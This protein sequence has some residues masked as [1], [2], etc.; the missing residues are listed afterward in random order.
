M[1]ALID[2]METS[3]KQD[4][5]SDGAESE[6]MGSLEMLS[7][8]WRRDNV[9]PSLTSDFQTAATHL[10]E[11]EALGFCADRFWP[12]DED[13]EAITGEVIDHYFGR[14]SGWATRMTKEEA[15]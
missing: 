9:L 4:D 12:E 3:D 13:Q 2:Q 7:G 1:V 15:G 5:S 10:V 14:R 11:E 8:I 6:W